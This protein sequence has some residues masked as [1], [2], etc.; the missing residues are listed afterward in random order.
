MSVIRS[1]ELRSG[2]EN[3]NGIHSGS[4]SCGKGTRGQR[5]RRKARYRGG[6]DPWVCCANSIQLALE[7]AMQSGGRDQAEND[8]AGNE[9]RS[10][11]EDELEDMARC[12]SQRD[13]NSDLAGALLHEI[14]ENAVDADGGKE[15]GDGSK[16]QCKKHGSSS[17]HER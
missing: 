4:A 8:S 1:T 5:N 10:F 12:T 3:S 14:R 6:Q 17:S 9:H 11:A 13:A 2:R 16:R 15:Q 7:K